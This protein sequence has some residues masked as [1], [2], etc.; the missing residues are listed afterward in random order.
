MLLRV[1][2][3]L[4]VLYILLPCYRVVLGVSR[5]SMRLELFLIEMRRLLQLS[6]LLGL[7]LGMF[8]VV[9]SRCRGGHCILTMRRRLEGRLVVVKK[10]LLGEFA[11]LRLVLKLKRERG[12]CVLFV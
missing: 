7:L 5:G 8:L 12:G 1:S 6:S 11:F 2:L 3:R 10:F 4:L 9:C